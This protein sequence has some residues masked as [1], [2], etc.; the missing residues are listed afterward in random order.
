[1]SEAIS[2]LRKESRSAVLT[3]T[4]WL[5]LSTVD[6]YLARG[7]ALQ[8]WWK[9]A[10]AAD[11]YERRFS[12]ERNFNRSGSSYGFFGQAPLGERSLSVMGNVQDLFY[13]RPKVPAWQIG[14]AAE[15]MK[16]QMREFALHY[17]MR[18]SSFRQPEPFVESERSAS[19]LSSPSWLSWC[20][21]PRITREGFGFSQIFYKLGGTGRIGRFLPDDEFAIVDL[22]ELGRRYEWIVAKV[23]IF[24]FN[25]KLRPFGSGPELVFGL[26]EESYLVLSP[27]FIL[28]EERPARGILG[29]YGLGYAF[30]KSPARGV[31]VWGPGQFEA[32]VELIQFQVMD[33]GE[34]SI[35]MVF[36]VDRPNKIASVTVD[37]VDWS[38]RIADLLSFGMTSRVFAPVRNTLNRLPLQFPEFDPVYSYIDLLNTISGGQSA[39]R[40]CISRDQLE[41]IFLQQHFMQH[42]QAIV[43]S[44]FTWRQIGNWLDPESLPDWVVSGRSS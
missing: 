42:Y 44:L 32:A 33:S 1:L 16:E 28:D 14:Q 13:D 11:G 41:R 23:H 25:F 15:W 17:F 38:L 8:R 34:I 3:A 10:D 29:R 5:L 26:D 21:R 20:Q 24:D 9:K 35:H 39:E 7:R 2:D 22:R 18:V 31:L 40:L 30:I 6:E 36:V 37:P 43:G 12:L 27:H 4:D 19:S